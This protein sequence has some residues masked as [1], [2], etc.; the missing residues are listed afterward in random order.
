V[1][2]EFNW[3]LLIVGLVVGAGLTWLVLADSS[4]READIEERELEPESLWIAERLATGHRQIDD[5]EV[6][7]ILRLHRT[8]RAA[9][10][11][12]ELDES[13]IEVDAE[14]LG[15]TRFEAVERA[16]MAHPIGGD[17]ARAERRAVQERARLP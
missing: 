8:Y 15:P 16:P 6:V 17:P 1:N 3:W 11:P 5:E 13:W 9:P 2:A 7:E 10:P 12:D 14:D 4:R